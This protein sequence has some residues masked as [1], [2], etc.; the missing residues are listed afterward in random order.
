MPIKTI[1]NISEFAAAI[2]EIPLKSGRTR[3]FR[4]HSDTKYKA[5]PSIFRKDYLINNEERI[6]REA[7]IRCP[8]E[9]PSS[10]SFLEVLVRL[11]HYSVPT[12]LLDLTSNA[13]VALYFACRHKEK[14]M[15]EVLVFDIPN[16]MIKYHDSDTVSII[17][18]L[19]NQSMDFNL[20]N[21][22]EN[23]AEFNNNDLVGRLLHDIKKDKPAFRP[24]INPTDLK[25]VIAVKT[26]L[27]N[28][29]I[30]RQDGAFLLFGVDGEKTK[31]AKI[32]DEWL[33]CGTAEN[34]INF[35]N[36]HKIKR[37]LEAFGVSEQTLFPE[38][39]SQAGAIQA[40]FSK[41]YARKK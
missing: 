40:K 5:S 31:P 6:I 8:S 36:K 3:F 14:T 27:D 20:N 9:L 4:G 15:G 10:L 38:L 33:V 34:K 17:A 29:R 22:P 25:K 19:A 32:P 35:S 41:K 26:R 11:Q 7:I 28:A 30:A 23:Q 12:R 2:S 16:E 1:R 37:E 21:L 13:L 39:D 24:I 18:N